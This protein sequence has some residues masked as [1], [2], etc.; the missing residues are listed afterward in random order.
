MYGNQV[1]AG[2]VASAPG[3]LALAGHPVRWRLLAELARSDR[4][5]RELTALAGLRRTWCPTIWASSGRAV[6]W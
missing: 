4:Q 1:A 2:K 3:F 6:W 5:V